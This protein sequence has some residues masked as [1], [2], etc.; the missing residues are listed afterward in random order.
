V[1][2]LPAVQRERIQM[3]L[4]RESGIII[5]I[6]IRNAPRPPESARSTRLQT[7]A[8]GVAFRPTLALV[9]RRVA[10]WSRDVAIRQV[11][12]RRLR[13]CDGESRNRP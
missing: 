5:K 10:Q 12:A 2:K 4:L 7:S 3:M 9:I 11:L 13:G 1:W 6:H 8:R